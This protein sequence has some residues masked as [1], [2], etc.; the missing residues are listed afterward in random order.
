V[1]ALANA[2]EELLLALWEGLGYY[3][4]VRN[5]K[6]AAVIVVERHGGELPAHFDALLALPGVGRYTAGA[7]A[8]IAFGLP[9][10]AVDGNVLRVFSRLTGSAEDVTLQQT[11]ASVA[12]MVQALLPDDRV[13]DFNQAVMEL[14]ATVCVPGA[15]ARC[16][17]CPAEA[18]CIARASGVQATLPRRGKKRAR[19]SEARSVILFVDELGCLALRRR[20]ANGLLAGLWEPYQFEGR[21]TEAAISE[22]LAEWGLTSV[23]APLA[24]AV[25]LFTHM[26]WHMSGWTVPVRERE[27]ALLPSELV[28]VDLAQRDGA[29]ALP[30]AFLPFISQLSAG[31]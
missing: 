5:M 21:A 20:Q 12:R 19:R 16:D 8:S 23:P 10:P 2:S 30:S 18:L 17:V 22:M 24:D 9:Y 31:R 6:R 26:E 1:A 15:E 3:N 28:W 25:H 14:G 4:R 27:K 11:K 13:G 29:Y 7:I